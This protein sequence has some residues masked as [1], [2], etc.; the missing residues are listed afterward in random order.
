MSRLFIY[1]FLNREFETRS[2]SGSLAAARRGF[3]FYVADP[4][5][6]IETRSLRGSL[7][8][9]VA[10]S[11]SMS[12]IP[13]APFTGERKRRSRVKIDSLPVICVGLYAA[14]HE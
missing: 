7:A 11:P 1:D 2:L 12:L 8:A 10:A 9:A 6:S 14:N 3:T 4:L 13:S 5:I